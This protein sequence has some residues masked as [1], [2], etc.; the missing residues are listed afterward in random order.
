MKKTLPVRPFLT[1]RV[2]S[3]LASSTSART[4]VD[5]WAVASLTRSP[6][7][8]SA[9]GACGSTSGIEV[10][11][12]GTPFLRSLTE[13]FL[14]AS[15]VG[16]GSCCH[17]ASRETIPA[18]VRLP[19]FRCWSGTSMGVGHLRTSGRCRMVS[20]AIVALA[21]VS[22]PTGLRPRRC[23]HRVRRGL[24]PRRRWRYP[25]HAH[26]DRKRQPRQP[27]RLHLGPLRRPWGDGWPP[28]APSN[29]GVVGTMVAGNDALDYAV[30]QFDPQKVRPVN[31]VNGFQIDGLGPDPRGRRHRLQ[32]GPHHRLLV[33]RDV[34]TGHRTGHHR[35]PGLRA[36]R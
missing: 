5:T 32:T 17:V 33:R 34:G 25:V 22:M 19:G 24:G 29:A 31:N 21:A 3:A 16:R 14:P 23:A 8:G 26:H 20:A 10:T 11:V 7:D 13:Y 35:Q 9:L 4:S 6:I 18:D 2:I 12:V 36:A 27:D 1:S 15:D 28:K 30:I